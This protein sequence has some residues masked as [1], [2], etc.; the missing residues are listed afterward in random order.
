MNHAVHK[1]FKDRKSNFKD[2]LEGG[3]NITSN[4]FSLFFCLTHILNRPSQRDGQVVRLQQFIHDDF[5]YIIKFMLFLS[6]IFLKYYLNPQIHLAMAVWTK[7][8]ISISSTNSQTMWTL[9][10]VSF[11]HSMKLS[12][13]PCKKVAENILSWEQWFENF[14]IW[15]CF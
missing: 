10:F 3:W 8:N 13:H 9:H 6:F 15:E 7:K 1:R 14:L 2:S 5:I 11:A 4:I 12:L